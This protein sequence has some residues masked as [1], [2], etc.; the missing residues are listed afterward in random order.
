MLTLGSCTNFHINLLFPDAAATT[1]NVSA[2]CPVDVDVDVAIIGAGPGGLAAAIALLK[3]GLTVRVFEKASVLRPAGSM[4]GIQPNGYNA[5]RMIDPPVCE[6]VLKAGVE[7]AFF[8]LCNNQ[9]LELNRTSFV[10]ANAMRVEQYGAPFK[11]VF[12]YRLQSALLKFL[13]EEALV[14]GHRLARFEEDDRGVSV[15][16]EGSDNPVRARLLVGADGGRSLVRQQLLGDGQPVYTGAMTW[17][18]SVPAADVAEFGAEHLGF[19]WMMGGGATFAVVEQGDGELLWTLAAEVGWE[20]KAGKGGDQGGG[21]TWATEK[22]TEKASVPSSKNASGSGDG[23]KNASEVAS[24]ETSPVLEVKKSE[25]GQENVHRALEVLAEWPE[26]VRAVV[27]ATAPGGVVETGVYHRAPVERWCS[28][29]VALVGDAAHIMR[30]TLGQGTSQA[31][32]DAL[33]LARELARIWGVGGGEEKASPEVALEAYMDLRRERVS[34]MQLEAAEVG[35]T[36]YKQGNVERAQE[37][38][39]KPQSDL[40]WKLLMPY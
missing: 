29:R 14:L 11:W 7:P 37:R 17:R 3:Q 27:K 33:V 36:A 38:T 31:F 20:T 9:G 22:A 24:H 13:P 5:L 10:A 21:G 19:Y 8:S 26:K 15:W 35:K 12:W 18:G 25:E 28:R 1:S 30:P 2:P 23:H 34:K 40:D 39:S 4:V 32:E 6:A 16:F